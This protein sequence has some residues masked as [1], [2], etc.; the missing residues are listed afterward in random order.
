KI[1]NYKKDHSQTELTPDTPVSMNFWGF[2]PSI[3]NAIEDLFVD[4]LQK[5]IDNTSSEFYIPFVI[6]NLLQADKIQVKVLQTNSQWYGIT[7]KEDSQ[8]VIGKFKEMVQSNI[9]PPVL[10]Q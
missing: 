7:Y 10:W 8:Y 1:N 2:H 9:Y 3:F 5:H 6:D 4:F